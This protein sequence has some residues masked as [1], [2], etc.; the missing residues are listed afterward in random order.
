MVGQALAVQPEAQ[1]DQLFLQLRTVLSNYL[2]DSHLE[3]IRRAYLL[4]AKAHSQQTRVSGEPYICHPLAVAMILAE[5]QMDAD[6]IAAALLHDVVEDTAVSR[7]QLIADFGE[8]VARL[9]DGVTKLDGLSNFSHA[10]TQAENVQKMVLAMAKDLRIIVLKLADRCHNMQTI[11]SLPPQKRRRIARETLEIYAPIAHRLS[12]NKVRHE[13]E[14]NGFRALYPMRYR[15]L[16]QA[17]LKAHGNRKEVVSA[18]KQEISTRLTESGLECK[19]V[20]RE[21]IPHSIYQKM[22]KGRI[23]FSEV[24]DVLGIRI[25]TDDVD[26]CYRALGVVHGLYQPVPG[27]FKDYVALPKKN[28]YQSLHTIV[29]AGEYECKVEVQIRTRS[30]H[31]LAQSGIAAHWNYKSESDSAKH[32]NMRANEWLQNILEI[33]KSAADSLE[34]LEH[35]KVDLFPDETYVL[36]PQGEIIKLPRGSSVI[37]F[38]Y[39]VHTDIGNTCLS[40]RVDKRLVPIQTVLHT[41]QTVEIITSKDARPLP[42]WLN[43][44]TTAKARVAV[45]AYLRDQKQGD[46]VQFGRTLLE[47]ELQQFGMK[48]DQVNESTMNT[49]LSAM[50]YASLND[51]LAAVGLGDRSAFIAANWLCQ[52][53][54]EGMKLNVDEQ[55]SSSVV[56]KGTEGMIVSLANCCH[57]IPG[58]HIVGLFHRNKGMVVHLS[59]CKNALEARSHQA[60]WIDVEWDQVIDEGNEFPVEL[61][62]NARNKKGTLSKIASTISS[63]GCNIEHVNVETQDSQVSR[64]TFI[65]TVKDRQHLAQLIRKLYRL[66]RVVRVKRKVS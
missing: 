32:S 8:D 21:K 15:I 60:G 43:Y 42:Q 12:M 44:V 51:Y 11:S 53:D 7:T 18:L 63:V 61:Q 22:R 62:L 52:S 19:V 23:P 36:T 57:P 17:A 49:F 20:G 27:H 29:L 31:R 26:A 10:E 9:V 14:N 54:A 34:F 3:M 59:H 2:K 40:A 58:D 46:A 50:K 4:A 66:D 16:K 25:I 39:A 64:N 13:L 45:R 56:I 37:D 41:G 65:V 28:G 33:Q 48:L 24:F 30:M 1:P 47:R 6:S 38:A 5:M 35:L 55:S